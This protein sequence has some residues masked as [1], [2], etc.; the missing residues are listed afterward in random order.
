MSELTC[1]Q[2]L[3]LQGRIE[4]RIRFGRTVQELRLD[5]FRRVVSFTTRQRVCVRPLVVE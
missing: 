2:L 3:W 4:N 1:V 5:H